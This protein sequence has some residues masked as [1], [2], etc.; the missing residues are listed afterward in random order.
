MVY[1]FESTEHIV[2]VLYCKYKVLVIVDTWYCFQ[3]L[4]HL[5]SLLSQ[6]LL[7]FP[8]C[9]RH[10]DTC[11]DATWLSTEPVHG[12]EAHAKVNAAANIASNMT[13]WTLHGEC[14]PRHECIVIA[15]TQE[16]M[17]KKSDADS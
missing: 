13:V 15:R 5:G 7:F 11:G 8:S 2:S 12:S 3:A 10:M 4:C 16:H 17:K 9:L 1:T 6:Q 14:R